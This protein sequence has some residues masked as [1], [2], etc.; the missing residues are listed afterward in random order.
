MSI[1]EQALP[2]SM[3]P[4]LARAA[5]STCAAQLVGRRGGR[6]MQVLRYLRGREAALRG[7][8]IVL[9]KLVH[10]PGVFCAQAGLQAVI[11]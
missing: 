10:R 8:P 3:P 11:R 2:S 1:D 9:E 7:G 4:R 5:R 6:R